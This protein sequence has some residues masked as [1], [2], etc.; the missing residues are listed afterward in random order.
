MSVPMKINRLS[1]RL[2]AVIAM[3]L[4]LAGFIALL[5]LLTLYHEREMETRMREPSYIA[6][7]NLLESAWARN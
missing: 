3:L 6:E 7:V 5:P 1:L 4:L 2:L